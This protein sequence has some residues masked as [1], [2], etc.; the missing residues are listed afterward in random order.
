MAK[1]L[2]LCSYTS[3]AWAAQ[4]KEPRNRLE[5]V[6]PL[7]ERLGGSIESAYLAFGEYDIVI[8]SEMPDNV[9]SAALSIAVSAG[10][11]V[12]IKTIPLIS[13]EEGMEAL[14]KAGELSYIP[15]G[16]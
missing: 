8:I 9:S 13:F 7:F 5:V 16:S 1:Y 10:G 11:A 4:I 12:S 14:K 15:P 3:A 6:R 2:S